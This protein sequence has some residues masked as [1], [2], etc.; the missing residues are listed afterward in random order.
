MQFHRFS[1]VIPCYRS[2]HTV[3]PVIDEIESVMATRPEVEYE[4]IAVSDCS[5]DNVM[6][7]LRDRARRDARVTA[8]ELARNMGRIC[9]LMAGFSQVTGDLI[10]VNDDDGQCPVDRV[11]DLAEAIGEDKDAAIADYP[12]K[13]QSAFK[14]FGSAVNAKMTCYVL[15]KP[16]DLHFT[17]FM[18][19]R[20]YI[21]DEIV[22]YENPYP[23]MTGLI[24]RTTSAGR[25]VNVPMEERERAAGSSGYTFKKMLALWFNG[26]TAFSVKPLRIATLVGACTACL[27]FLWGLITVI[28]KVLN[29]GRILA[30][31]SSL[32]AVLLF[33]GGILM[34][35]LGLLGE[36]IGRSYISINRSP[37]YVIRSI[38]KQEPEKNG[39]EDGK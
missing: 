17:N 34:L 5:P 27:G 33:I 1:F 30:G 14:N 22:R 7:V 25:I 3:I 23:Y 4:I 11:F 18:A 10:V 19:L 12:V 38:Y 15:D 13:K 21:V 8:V 2:E 20:R 26:L 28:R 39:A 6:G 35:M 31:Y 32:L 16:D 9:A 24:L 36:Y 37:Q 29:P